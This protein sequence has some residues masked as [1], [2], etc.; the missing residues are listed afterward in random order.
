MWQ[1]HKKLL[2]LLSSPELWSEDLLG[3]H[4]TILTYIDCF[5]LVTVLKYSFLTLHPPWQLSRWIGLGR[6]EVV[7]ADEVNGYIQ[8]HWLF[9]PILRCF[10]LLIVRYIWLTSWQ[11]VKHM[12]VGNLL[13]FDDLMD[14]TIP[15]MPWRKEILIKPCRYS[16]TLIDFEFEWKNTG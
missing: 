3:L 9:L 12:N 4:A 14:W 2:L 5:E 7:G 1:R 13:R 8:F 16:S 10:R 15:R 11:S 6:L